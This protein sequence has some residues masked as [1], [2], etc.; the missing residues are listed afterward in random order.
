MAK[1]NLAK[2]SRLEIIQKYHHAITNGYTIN[3][4]SMHAGIQYAWV[5]LA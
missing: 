2:L 5:H 3:H 4:G 1:V